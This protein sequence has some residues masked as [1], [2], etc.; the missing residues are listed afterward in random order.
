[1]IKKKLFLLLWL[2]NQKLIKMIQK[3]TD[4]AIVII[5]K[6]KNNKNKIWILKLK[7]HINII[8]NHK[9]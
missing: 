7:I 8:K 3:N 1:M 2:L 5:H 6:N 4:I 9:I